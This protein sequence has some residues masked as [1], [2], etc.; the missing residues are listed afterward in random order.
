MDAEEL[1]ELEAAIAAHC[2]VLKT[3]GVKLPVSP[4]QLHVIHLMELSPS[5][6]RPP[7]ARALITN[8]RALA[9]Q[10]TC[11]KIHEHR[12]KAREDAERAARNA[13]PKHQPTAQRRAKQV[14]ILTDSSHF[15]RL[16]PAL[17]DLQSRTRGARKK[18]KTF[19]SALA[20]RHQQFLRHGLA[21][22]SGAEVDRA[23]AAW[24]STR[25]AVL[26]HEIEF[27]VAEIQGPIAIEPTGHRGA[28]DNRAWHRIRGEAQLA[29]TEAGV[30]AADRRALFP[31]SHPG[32]DDFE[33]KQ[34]RREREYKVRKRAKKRRD[35]KT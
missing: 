20:A 13:K 10:R 24:L 27:F 4:Q 32:K 7:V 26:E 22:A 3:D 21:Y 2:E 11:A 34:R 25:C 14:K 28:A 8:L 9:S 6:T 30:T 18:L 17:S 23:L 15:E 12:A 29:L 19:R 33:A 1:A 5:G 35:S 31:I 16:A